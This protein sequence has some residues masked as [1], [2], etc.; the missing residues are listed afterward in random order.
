MESELFPGEVVHGGTL[1]RLAAFSDGLSGGN[2][3]GV[4]LGEV[5]PSEAAMQALATSVGYSETAFL[6]PLAGNGHTVRYFS[7]GGEVPF[8]G[9]A[10][11]ASGA[12]LAAR[13]GEDTYV[14]HTR[15]GPVPVQA[16]LNGGGA[17][18]SLTS[19]EPRQGPVEAAV[20]AE[21]LACLGWSLGDLD[22]ALPPL[23]AFAG[24]W[25]LVL[26]AHEP[27]LLHSLTY[28]FERL[29]ALMDT[30]GLLTLQLV[31]RTS[32]N[33]FIARNPAPTCGVVEDPATGSAA[34]A[35]GGYLRSLGLV[36]P[37]CRITV[38][39]GQAMG[40]PG[41]LEISIPPS[42]GIAVAGTVV[43]LKG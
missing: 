43:A 32:P 10:S 4:W 1:H 40:R 26:A 23:R 5:L 9:H 29:R 30:E 34:A 13:S 37:P 16:Q 25:H 6:A 42:G 35:L 21:V 3:A 31:H 14:L 2:P 18:A 36:D 17:V 28:P 24:A 38:L 15:V 11:I 22:P 27:T 39:Q 8:C 19:V 33:V 7:P 41:R 20:L 12:L